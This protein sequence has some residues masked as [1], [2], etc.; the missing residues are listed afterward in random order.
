MALAE[1][2]E[3]GLRGLRERLQPGLEP[4]TRPLVI[5]VHPSIDLQPADIG[6][7]TDVGWLYEASG[8]TVW[9]IASPRIDEIRHALA[10]AGG[11]GMVPTVLH[12]SGSVRASGGAVALTFLGGDWY[13]EALE[14]TRYSDE[15]TVTAVDSLLKLIPHD[16]SRPLVV[17]DVERPE[18]TTEAITHLLLRNL[19][20][21]DLFALGRCSAVLG[22]G[23]AALHQRDPYLR[24]VQSLA[25]RRTIGE[26]AAHVREAGAPG[27]KSPDGLETAL[28]PLGTALYTNVPWLRPV[29]R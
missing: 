2:G 4:G 3:G 28:G 13:S 20:A 19:F 9:R 29:S 14:G 1:D 10:A 12:L 6:H 22:T 16:S 7:S 15:L 18:S 11:E 5:L 25:E 23:L 8:F 17:I 21:G 27:A 26:I 24:L